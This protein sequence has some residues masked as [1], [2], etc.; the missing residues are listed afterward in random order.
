MGLGADLFRALEAMNRKKRLDVEARYLQQ[1]QAE[2]S[3]EIQGLQEQMKALLH[4]P[5]TVKLISEFSPCILATFGFQHDND[6]NIIAD[7]G[8][9]GDNAEMLP[10]E[11]EESK[12]TSSKVEDSKPGDLEAVE[13]AEKCILGEL[14]CVD[15]AE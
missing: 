1:R 6:G 10:A 13:E 14:Q 12:L 8:V 3:L 4:K 9:D 7:S 15:L 2:I 11:D 5:E